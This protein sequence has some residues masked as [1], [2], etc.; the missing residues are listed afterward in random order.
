VGRTG[1]AG[2]TGAGVSFVLGDQVRDMR[3]IARD[4]GL[5]DQFDAADGTPV[6][7]PS[8]GPHNNRTRPQR[9]GGGGG[10][11]NNRNRSRNRGNGGG[12]G[13]GGGGKPKAK[14][15]GWSSDGRGPRR[16]GRRAR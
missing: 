2:N 1:R 15:Q 3:K 10:G 5:G 16:Q 9:G 4:L 11:G 12:N 7:V 13:G 8:D 14:A 6:A